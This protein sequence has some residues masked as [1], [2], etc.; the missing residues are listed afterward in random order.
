MPRRTDLLDYI[1]VRIKHLR[2]EQRM[3]RRQLA[4]KAVVPISTI[5]A[6]EKGA[7]AGRWLTVETATK[8]AKALG[9]SMT[10]FC[11]ED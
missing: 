9:V 6:V 3:N 1:G 10:V 5:S 8:L 7:R 11:A 4:S 2:T